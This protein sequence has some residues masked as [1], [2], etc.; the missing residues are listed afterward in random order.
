M[1]FNA[2]ERSMNNA[3]TKLPTSVSVFMLSVKDINASSVEK[4]GQKP[5]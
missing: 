2:F 4:P 5:N 1:E 3:A